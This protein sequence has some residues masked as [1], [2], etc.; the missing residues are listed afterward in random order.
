[1]GIGETIFAGT[2]ER[3]TAASEEAGLAERRRELIAGARGRVLEIGGGLGANLAYYGPEVESVTLAE[4]GPAMAKRLEGRLA[5]RRGELSF[6][7]E[8][9]RAPAERL[10]FERDSF[11]TVVSTLV[12]CA[13]GDQR[14]ALSELRRVLKPGGQLL[15]LEHVR[16][17]GRTGTM[18]DRLNWLNRLVV[19]CNCNRDTLASITASGFTVSSLEHGE[20][21]K[22]PPFVRPLIV[23]SAR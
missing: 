17:D 11:D 12:L 22:A 21:P 18:Q 23:G 8:L 14:R 7:V 9:V 10:P 4:P 16:G 2:Y 20:L 5:E 3:F 6:G 15:F 19:R 13:V 1:V